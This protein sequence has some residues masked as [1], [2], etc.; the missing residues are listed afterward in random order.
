MLLNGNGVR[1]T[2]Y[3]T[4]ATFFCHPLTTCPELN[5][6]NIT[7]SCHKNRTVIQ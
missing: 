3:I 4:S 6:Q 1:S 2:T 5:I 7:R